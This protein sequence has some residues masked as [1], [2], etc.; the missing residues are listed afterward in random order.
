MEEES[1]EQDL[2]RARNDYVA[3]VAE[4]DKAQC[5]LLR[6]IGGIRPDSVPVP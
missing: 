1:F 4:Y 3:V 6:A 2:T 5:T